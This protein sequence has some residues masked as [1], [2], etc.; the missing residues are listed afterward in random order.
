[1]EVHPRERLEAERLLL[2]AVL[3]H[4][5]CGMAGTTNPAGIR[6]FCQTV[7]KDPGAMAQRILGVL[8]PFLESMG[9]KRVEFESVFTG[10]LLAAVDKLEQL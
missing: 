6:E 10:L 5:L 7:R 4:T 9:R 8:S 1:M 3:C 2:V